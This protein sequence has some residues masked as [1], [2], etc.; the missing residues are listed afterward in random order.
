MAGLRSRDGQDVS[1]EPLVWVVTPVYNGE[2]YLA[3]CIESVLAQT[4]E[5]WRYLVVDNCSTDRTAEIVRAYA[6]RDA[7]VQLH[8]SNEFLPIISNWNR[9]LRLIPDE[10]SY[11]KVVHADDTL[12]PECL[13][14][15][16]GLAERNTSVAIVTSYALWGDEVRHQGVPYPVEVVDGR[17]ICRL[18]LLGHCYVFGSP[19]SLLL[20]AADVRARAAF[21]NEQ[22]LHADSEVCFELLREGDL[23]FVQQIL[24]RTR[25]HAEATTSFATRV[26]TFHYGWLAIHVKYGELYLDRRAHY[27]WLAYR[28]QRYGVFLANALVKAKFRDPQFRQ[29]H[30]VAI[31]RLLRSLT[32][33]TSASRHVLRKGQPTTSHEADAQIESE[34]LRHR[35]Q[36]FV[37]RALRR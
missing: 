16:V 4:Y 19:T 34:P 8:Q 14:R 1:S 35:Q 21:Y 31:G 25:V 23:G 33:R 20:R 13:E 12:L 24:T 15:M 32:A 30:R 5:N 9:A 6:A 10:A 36:R 7:R 2:R 27:V 37:S 29:H 11:C 26:N 3:E 18:T 17:K 22:N 28:L